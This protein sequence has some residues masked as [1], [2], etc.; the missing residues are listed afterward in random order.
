MKKFVAMLTASIVLALSQ[1][2]HAIPKTLEDWAVDRMSLWQP[3]GR[4]SY[5]NAR[6]TPEAGLA[7]Y[8]AIARDVIAVTYDPSE[9]PLFP[10]PYGRAKTAAT[11][12]SMSDFESGYR[13]DVDTGEGE[14][15]RGDGGKSW[16]LMQIQLGVAVHGRTAIR[17]KTDGP[18][19]AWTTNRSEGWGGEDLVRDR[20][21]CFRAALHIIRQSFAVCSSLPLNEK[22]SMYASG[23]CTDGRTASR[24][25]MDQ[26]IRWLAQVAPPLNDKQTLDSITQ[27]AGV[28]AED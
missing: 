3:P 16:C 19:F 15:A 7:R 1:A 13:K 17:I 11:I 18:Y 2:S 20:Q 6:E 27:S 28:L 26:A 25:R 12:L 23:N 4:S 21:S 10:G 14:D 5:Q 24:I 8:H 9:A 22:L